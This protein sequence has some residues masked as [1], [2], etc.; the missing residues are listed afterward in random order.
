MGLFLTFIE[1]TVTELAHILPLALAFFTLLLTLLNYQTP[2]L[3]VFD[4]IV[5][6]PSIQGISLPAKIL[7]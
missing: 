5:L 2:P 6:I 7:L 3:E 4:L 1:V